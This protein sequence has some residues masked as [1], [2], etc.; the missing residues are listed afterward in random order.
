[1]GIVYMMGLVSFSA[2]LIVLILFTIRDSEWAQMESA[3]KPLVVKPKATPLK[4]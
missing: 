2:A 1:L 4:E 3:I